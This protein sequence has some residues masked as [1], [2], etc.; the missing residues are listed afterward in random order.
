M[1]SSSA[2]FRLLVWRCFR[3]ILPNCNVRDLVP[4]IC[5]SWFSM[6]YTLTR[7][8][9]I[10][11]IPMIV[12]HCIIHYSTIVCLGGT[13]RRPTFNRFIVRLLEKSKKLNLVLYHSPRDVDCRHRPLDSGNHYGQGA[14]FRRSSSFLDKYRTRLQ[15]GLTDFPVPLYL[16]ILLSSRFA[17]IPIYIYIRCTPTVCQYVHH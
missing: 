8:V 15:D 7:A 12:N 11:R 4:V 5:F 13:H 1:L 6:L 14:D 2:D 9:R 17:H 3:F 10:P 16:I